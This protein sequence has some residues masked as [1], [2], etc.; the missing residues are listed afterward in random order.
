MA[1]E[2]HKIKSDKPSFSQK[3][4]EKPRKTEKN[5]VYLLKNLRKLVFL[6]DKLSFS[7]KPSFSQEKLSYSPEKPSFSGRK[8]GLSDFGDFRL[9]WKPALKV[10]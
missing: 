6:P 3:N 5:R 2:G 7:E 4:R 8:P 10:S 9:L 1:S